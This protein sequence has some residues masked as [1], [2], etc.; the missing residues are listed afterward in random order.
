MSLSAL[1]V[2]YEEPIQLVAHAQ[3]PYFAH[4]SLHNV[5]GNNQHRLRLHPRAVGDGILRD[6]ARCLLVESGG[7]D[8]LYRFQSYDS[9]AVE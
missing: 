1:A 7:A 5:H 9:R 8:D 2:G 6:I 3:I 4:G